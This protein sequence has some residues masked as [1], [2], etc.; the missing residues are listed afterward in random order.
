MKDNSM[1]TSKSLIL[2]VRY[3]HGRYVTRIVSWLHTWYIGISRAKMLLS[4]AFYYSMCYDCFTEWKVKASSL[5]LTDKYGLVLF[6]IKPHR[7]YVLK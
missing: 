7:D 2:S 1:K 6:V 3:A 5:I 4:T